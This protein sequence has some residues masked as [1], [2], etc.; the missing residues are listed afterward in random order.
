MPARAAPVHLRKIIGVAN[1]QFGR[2]AGSILFDR[3]N[4]IVCS[5]KTGRVRH[6]YH[7]EKLIATLRPTDGFLALTIY[8][9]RILLDKLTVVPNT[10]TVQ[11]D[12]AEFITK[13]GDVFAKHIVRAADTIRPSDEVIV[14][15]EAGRLLGVGSAL[16][17]GNDMKHFRRGVAVRVRRGTNEKHTDC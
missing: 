8:G 17:S 12:V 13:G 16:L 10:V 9:A 14:T 11:S 6:I 5:R 7:G 1:Y 4:R 2:G 3:N 15:D